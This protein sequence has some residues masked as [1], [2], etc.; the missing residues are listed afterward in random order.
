[1]PS[2]ED[3]ELGCLISERAAIKVEDQVNLTVSQGGKVILGGNRNGAFYDPTVIIDVPKTADVA[4][5][6]EIFGPVVPIITFDTIEEAIE[7]ANSSKF[8]LCGCVFSQNMKNAFYE[9]TH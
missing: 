6:M 3:S 7:I 2:D 9:L 1:M 8:G 5:D 4:I